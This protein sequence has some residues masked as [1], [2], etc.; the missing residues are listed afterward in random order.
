MPIRVLTELSV[1]SIERLTV[2]FCSK[3]LCNILFPSLAAIKTAFPLL[4]RETGK[5]F[6]PL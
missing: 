4:E 2:N 3:N 6:A 5:S 1:L